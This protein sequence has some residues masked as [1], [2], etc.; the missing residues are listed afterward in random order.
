MFTKM[1]RPDSKGRISLGVLTKGI[2]GF[3]MHQEQNG[4]I[5]LEPFVE[6]PA[7]E[8]WLF[9]NTSALS[10][11][12]KGLEQAKH[13]ALVDKGGFSQFTEDEIE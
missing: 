9:E 8:T 1:L 13:G 11:V 5:V 7:N 6:I 4:R 10:K 3:S 2:S 12:R